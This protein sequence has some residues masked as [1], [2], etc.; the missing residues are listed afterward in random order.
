MQKHCFPAWYSK[1]SPPVWLSDQSWHPQ[2]HPSPGSTTFLATS[3]EHLPAMEIIWDLGFS[4]KIFLFHAVQSTAPGC[5]IRGWM[6]RPLGWLDP[7]DQLVPFNTGAKE[8]GNKKKTVPKAACASCHPS[9][10]LVQAHPEPR[11]EG[12]KQVWQSSVPSGD[13]A[14]GWIQ[15]GSGSGRLLPAEGWEGCAW[16]YPVRGPGMLCP[17]RSG[18]GSRTEVRDG[19]G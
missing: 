12:G 14:P 3:S 9:V 19:R 17:D 5:G 13:A 8:E 18:T 10:P 7:T 4:P 15:E 6:P 2:T 16:M 1:R 11:D